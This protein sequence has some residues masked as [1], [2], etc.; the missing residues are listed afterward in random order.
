VGLI[1]FA[2]SQLVR[3][4]GLVYP[5]LVVLTIVVTGNHFV[6]DAVAGMAVLGVGF[7]LVRGFRRRQREQGSACAA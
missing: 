3:L 6:L 2:R 1:R 4:G 5:P 7:L